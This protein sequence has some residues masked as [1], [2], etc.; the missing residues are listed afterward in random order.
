[1]ESYKIKLAKLNGTQKRLYPDLVEELIGEKY[2]I[3][4]QIAII[5]Q[6]D[7]KPEEYQEFFDYAEYCKIM[8]KMQLEIED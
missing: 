6:K 3:G 4:A 5:R 7:E 1:M 8:A 2:S